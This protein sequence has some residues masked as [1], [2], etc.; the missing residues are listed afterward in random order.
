MQSSLVPYP[1]AVSSLSIS[2][3]GNTACN[4]AHPKMI[5]E[6]SQWAQLS[7]EHSQWFCLNAEASWQGH[8][9]QNPATMTPLSSQLPSMVCGLSQVGT[10]LVSPT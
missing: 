9:L 4:L 8:E 1:V 5:A 7:V 10:M 3:P 6:P 2:L